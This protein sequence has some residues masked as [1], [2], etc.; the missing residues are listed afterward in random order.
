MALISECQDNLISNLLS[1][2]S[3]IRG[4]RPPLKDVISIAHKTQPSVDNQ[5]FW[6]NKVYLLDK[7]TN[8]MYVL[9]C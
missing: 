2:T 3:C 6:G 4:C 9:L 1:Q 7:L 5:F 8:Q